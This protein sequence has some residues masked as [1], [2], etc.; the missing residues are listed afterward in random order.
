MDITGG[1]DVTDDRGYIGYD[2]GVTGE[3]TVDGSGSTWTNNSSLDVGYLGNGTLDITNGGLVIVAGILSIDP[4]GGDDSF[5]NMSTG[6]MLALI[7]SSWA[8]GDNLGDFLDLIRGNDAI[9]YWDGSAWADITGGTY[10]VDYTLEHL[11]TGDLAGY[12]M[13]AVPEPATLSLLAL[14]GL[15]ILR[16]RKRR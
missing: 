10:G 4:N 1:N 16:R 9:N 14:G 6:G 12:T 3:V 8:S 11:T 5:V 2:S 15:A 7:D 13:L